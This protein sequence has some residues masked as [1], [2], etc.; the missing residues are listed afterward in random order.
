MIDCQTGNIYQM[1]TQWQEDRK[2]EEGQVRDW[3]YGKRRHKSNTE[4][5]TGKQK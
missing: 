5:L 3:E 2:Q 1:E 4:L